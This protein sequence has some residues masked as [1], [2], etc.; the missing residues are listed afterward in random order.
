MTE[1]VTDYHAELRSAMLAQITAEY[2]DGLG[3][4]AD[5]VLDRVEEL[6]TA[7][8]HRFM[9]AVR[10]DALEESDPITAAALRHPD[11]IEPWRYA[12]EK[13]HANTVALMKRTARRELDGEE[14]QPDNWWTEKRRLAE[15]ARNAE[16]DAR[17]LV[18]DLRR[19]VNSAPRPDRASRPL[20]TSPRR[21][22][23][24]ARKAAWSRLEAAHPDE[25]EKYLREELLARDLTY[26]PRSERHAHQV[27]EGTRT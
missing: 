23:T 5:A 27:T 11:L 16:R 7:P 12:L 20:T 13:L 15:H 26:T 4:S 25:F 14:P 6:G 18:S 9:E 17:H 1:P 21:G 2:M 10:M 8:E 24:A 3:D 22:W 19:R